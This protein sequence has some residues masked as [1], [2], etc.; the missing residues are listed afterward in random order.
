MGVPED[1]NGGL[2]P[3]FYHVLQGGSYV[4]FF[5]SF[6]ET[7]KQACKMMVFSDTRIFEPIG[8]VLILS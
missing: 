2:T 1:G 8:K 7:V 4:K 6:P 3:F 5:G